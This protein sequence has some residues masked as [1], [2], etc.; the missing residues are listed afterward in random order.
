MKSAKE[1][2]LI[3][4]NDMESFRELYD[5]AVKREAETF[6]FKGHEVL[7][8]YAKYVIEYYDSKFEK[9]DNP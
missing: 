2:V 4:E 9:N 5:S 8:A 1:V 6:F 7:T 3:T